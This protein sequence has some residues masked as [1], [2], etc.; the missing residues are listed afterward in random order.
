M[1][2]ISKDKTIDKQYLLTTNN[3]KMKRKHQKKEFDA[4]QVNEN[5][6][7]KRAQDVDELQQRIEIMKN[8]MASKKSKPSN[9]ALKKKE[10]KRL[11]KENLLKKR[12]I[13]I[14][15]SNKNEKIKEHKQNEQ[16]KTDADKDDNKDDVKMEP[17]FNE[18][19]K[20][21]FS[22]FDFAARKNKGKKSKKESKYF[23]FIFFKAPF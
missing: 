17:I 23:S 8:K 15:K 4:K 6:N 20:M 14:A 19:G 1:S 11:K 5:G 7:G 3:V 10:L 21:V 18:E 22:R 12:V 16:L 13:S 2:I 9:K